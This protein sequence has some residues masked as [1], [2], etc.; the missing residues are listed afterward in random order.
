MQGLAVLII[1]FKEHALFKLLFR[2]C[3]LYLTPIDTKSGIC[4]IQ[5]T[6]FTSCPLPEPLTRPSIGG[7]RRKIEVPV[8]RKMH[9]AAPEY[10]TRDARSVN[11]HKLAI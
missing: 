8:V 6:L 7:R 11:S 10:T 3:M 1:A 4:C 5:T 2:A 9:R